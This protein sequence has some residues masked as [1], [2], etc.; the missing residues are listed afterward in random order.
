MRLRCL[1]TRL[2]QIVRLPP[3]P[4]LLEHRQLARQLQIATMV[5]R[6]FVLTAAVALALV[7]FVAGCTPS[8][9]NG[10]PT[11]GDAS[12][13]CGNGETEEGEQCD[14][15]NF[16][17]LDGCTVECK[18]TGNVQCGNA[19]LDGAEECDDGNSSNEDACVQGCFI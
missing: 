6:D 14:D 8:S 19:K 2:L 1:H 9:D 17:D 10:Q 18:R 11:G 3:Q 4:E 13:S 12:P 15:G 5:I 7:A 16:D